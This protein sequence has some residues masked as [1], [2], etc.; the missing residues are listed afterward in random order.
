MA[1]TS[2][3]KKEHILE[4]QKRQGGQ[5]QGSPALIG[6]DLDVYPLSMSPAKFESLIILLST[7]SRMTT[8]AIQRA[9]EY[10]NIFEFLN[11]VLADINDRASKQYESFLKPYD[12]KRT[13]LSEAQEEIAPKMLAIRDKLIADV[14][15]ERRIKGNILKTEIQKYVGDLMPHK[16]FFAVDYGGFK[17]FMLTKDSYGNP[18]KKRAGVINEV[19]RVS[20][21]ATPS[22]NTI[23]SCLEDLEGHGYVTGIPAADFKKN[24]KLRAGAKGAWYLTHDF[25]ILWDKKRQKMLEEYDAFYKKSGDPIKALYELKERYAGVK[26]LDFYLV[27]VGERRAY[28]PL[29]ASQYLAFQEQVSTVFKE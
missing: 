26:L 5:I 1:S 13:S 12:R 24:E 7:R 18:E 2:E 17:A 25:V 28:P 3:V 14:I 9:I 19:R 6:D 20:N 10:A 22:Y 29:I 16:S 11:G 23:Q 27:K 4:Y 21:I 15:H 8:K